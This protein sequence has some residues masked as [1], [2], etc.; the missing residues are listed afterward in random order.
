MPDRA[1]G[2]DLFGNIRD[3]QLWDSLHPGVGGLVGTED[4]QEAA[5]LQYEISFVS[6]V[7]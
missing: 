2:V 5:L 1:V 7:W 4:V 3:L 6:M